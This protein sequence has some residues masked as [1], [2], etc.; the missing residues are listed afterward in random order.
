MAL[1]DLSDDARYRLLVEA[2]TDYAI[3]MLDPEG[4]VSSWNAGAQRC[5]GYEA[6]EIIGQHFSR[7]YTDADQR[8][9]CHSSPSQPQPKRGNSRAKVGGCVRMAHAS[10]RTSSSIR[11]EI[12]TDRL[13]DIPRS[14]AISRSGKKRRMHSGKANSNSGYSCKA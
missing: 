9:G 6:S 14:H 12:E 7:F 1:S 2:V 3:Y 4:I 10:G 13:S 8:L 5:K 11:S